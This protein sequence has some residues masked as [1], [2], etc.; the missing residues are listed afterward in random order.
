MSYGSYGAITGAKTAQKMKT[1]RIEN[2]TEPSKDLNNS[3]KKLGLL[4][5]RISPL[6]QK[7]PAEGLQKK[8]ANIT[9]I[10]VIKTVACNKG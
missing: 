1:H 5:T 10:I 4:L 6:D 8:F 9:E 7:P 2:P 3:L